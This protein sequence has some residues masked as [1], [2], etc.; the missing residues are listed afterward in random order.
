MD[1]GDAVLE[2]E[3]GVFVLGFCA[4]SLF[5]DPIYDLRFSNVML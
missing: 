1:G 2:Q 3:A 4:T 5:P